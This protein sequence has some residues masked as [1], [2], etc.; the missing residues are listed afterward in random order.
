MVVAIV[1]VV[2]AAITTAEPQSIAVVFDVEDLEVAVGVRC[3]RDAIYVHC[4]PMR[5]VAV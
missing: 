3:V 1:E 5:Q 4:P 2:R